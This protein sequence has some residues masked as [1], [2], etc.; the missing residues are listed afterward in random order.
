MYLKRSITLLLLLLFSGLAQA[1]SESWQ[2]FERVQHAVKHFNYD[3]SFVVQKGAQVHTYRWLHG[4]SDN[5]KME[6]LVSLDFKGVDILRRED[7]IYYLTENRPTL[8]TR[9]NNIK[10]LP[11]VLFEDSQQIQKLYHIFL[12][13]SMRLS[14]RSAQLL[15]LS[16]QHPGKHH[17]WLWVDVQS[18][19]PL[20]IETYSDQQQLLESWQ[21]THTQISPEFPQELQA[22]ADADLPEPVTETPQLNIAD[23]DIHYQLDWL[24]EGFTVLTDKPVDL[25]PLNDLLGYW[26]LTD[27]LHQI[28]VFVKK[29]QQ[30]PTNIYNDGATTIYVQ[31]NSQLEVTVIGP[32]S[33]DIAR[34]LASAV[35]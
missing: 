8:V 24:P 7:V 29:S 10:E 3:T 20:R 27:G 26:L 30:M 9:G 15:R 2:L 18:G 14:G 22:L 21:V 25:Q 33:M 35:H 19:Y 23:S 32:I 4:Y 5:I 1:S 34:K 16:P 12:G 28:S 11:A 31:S 6:Y 13:S 17:Y